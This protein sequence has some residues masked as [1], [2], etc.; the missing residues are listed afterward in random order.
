M[1]RKALF[2]SVFLGLLFIAIGGCCPS[3]PSESAQLLVEQV[4]VG[5][6]V[7]QV[8][9][10]YRCSDETAL[11]RDVN[12][13]FNQNSGKVEIIRVLQSQSGRDSRRTTISVF[14]KKTE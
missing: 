12:T 2:L 3:T 10:F 14:Y 1:I 11:Q 9:I 6:G 13:W 8:V 5:V 7:E 4:E